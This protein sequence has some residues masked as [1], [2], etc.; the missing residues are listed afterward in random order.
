MNLKNELHFIIITEKNMC[1]LTLHLTSSEI[2]K[3]YKRF[4]TSSNKDS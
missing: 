4:I 1:F 2:K 3:H